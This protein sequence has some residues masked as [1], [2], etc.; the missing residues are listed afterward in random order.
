M[1]HF[2]LNSLYQ[3][4]DFLEFKREIFA[5][6]AEVYAPAGELMRGGSRLS[7]AKEDGCQTVHHHLGVSAFATHLMNKEMERLDYPARGLL[8]A[9]S[10][11]AG[12]ILC[13]QAGN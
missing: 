1:T 9:I 6:F 7:C 8:D 3:V 10:D 2:E 5:A 4:F 12:N 11:S 13:L